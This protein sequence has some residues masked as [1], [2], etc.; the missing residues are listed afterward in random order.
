MIQQSLSF[1]VS[2]QVKALGWNGIG[3]EITGLQNKESDH[4]LNG[5]KMRRFKKSLALYLQSS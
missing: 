5:S 1:A 3:L 2:D 4:N